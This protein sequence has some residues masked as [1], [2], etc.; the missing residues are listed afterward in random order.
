VDR[1]KGELTVVLIEDDGDV[2]GEVTPPRCNLPA[3]VE[4]ESVLEIR[5]EGGELIGV[6][7]DPE[8][9]RAPKQNARDRFDRLSRRPDE[10][11]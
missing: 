11:E 8:A 5:L 2:V 1:I 9:T 3:G 4:P 6:T 7:E 10:T